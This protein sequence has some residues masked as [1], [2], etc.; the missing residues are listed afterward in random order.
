MMQHVGDAHPIARGRSDGL[1][2]IHPNDR[3][4]EFESN[5]FERG[6]LSDRIRGARSDWRQGAKRRYAIAIECV[7]CRSR[8]ARDAVEQFA[9]QLKRQA[10]IARAMLMRAFEG[11]SEA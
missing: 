4:R 6:R 11:L 1:I 9:R 7:A 2:A 5:F 3:A 8:I 10:A